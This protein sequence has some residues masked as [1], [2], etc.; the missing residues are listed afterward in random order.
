MHIVQYCWGPEEM[1][2]GNLRTKEDKFVQKVRNWMFTLPVQCQF[3]G[4]TRNIQDGFPRPKE[5]S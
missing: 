3:L 1:E 4:S 2:A 5:S